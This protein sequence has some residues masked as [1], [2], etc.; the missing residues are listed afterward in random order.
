MEEQITNS[1]SGATEPRYVGFWARFLAM[2]IDNIWVTI[3]LVLVLMAIVGQD[4]MAM[5]AMTP[6][7]SP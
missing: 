2:F 3:V 1:A 7:A 6:D 4:F 5:M